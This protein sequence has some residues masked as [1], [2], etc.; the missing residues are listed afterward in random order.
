MDELGLSDEEL[1]KLFQKMDVQTIPDAARAV[2]PR[3]VSPKK[4]INFKNILDMINKAGEKLKNPQITITINETT[5]YF[6]RDSKKLNDIY[7]SKREGDKWVKCGYIKKDGTFI[8]ENS[9][10]IRDIGMFNENPQEFAKKHGALSGKCCFCN[11]ELTNEISTKNG[12]GP[13]CAGN[14]GLPYKK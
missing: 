2:S 8:E 5:Y 6:Y 13:T 14:Y 10:K 4:T 11:K 3:K 9:S 1:D 12:Y 7:I